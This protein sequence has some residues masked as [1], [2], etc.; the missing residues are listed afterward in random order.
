MQNSRPEAA[1]AIVTVN[2]EKRA[3]FTIWFNSPLA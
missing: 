3:Y 1:V 2:P